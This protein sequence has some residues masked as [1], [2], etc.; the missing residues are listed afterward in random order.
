MER[1]S[2]TIE[3]TP[4]QVETAN[5]LIAFIGRWCENQPEN[6]AAL[7][8]AEDDIK[9]AKQFREELAKQFLQAGK[10][11]P[12]P[13]G[14]Q[15]APNVTDHSVLTDASLMPYGKHKGTPMEQVPASYLLWLYDNNRTT[16]QVRAYIVDNRA[17][18][19]KEMKD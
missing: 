5:Y 10:A 11:K 18:L 3:V 9:A 14:K 6:L 19:E 1:I 4:K 17:V 13:G 16:D 12:A 2:I 15:I 7:N 8:L